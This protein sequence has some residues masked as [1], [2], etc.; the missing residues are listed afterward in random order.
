[1][2]VLPLLDE[3][4][5]EVAGVVDRLGPLDGDGLAG[6]KRR[7]ERWIRRSRVPR[8]AA[9]PIFLFRGLLLI[10]VVATF[11]GVEADVRMSRSG[12]EEHRRSRKGEGESHDDLTHALATARFE[13]GTRTSGRIFCTGANA[14]SFTRARGSK[15]REQGPN[16]DP[17]SRVSPP[18]LSGRSDR[19]G[20]ARYR[21]PPILRRA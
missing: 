17:S 6:R 21:P 13:Q 19:A 3:S 2:K 1:R 14:P 9:R 16:R 4:D 5:S 15:R 20:R 11:R 12:S 7:D 8:D 10:V 18:E